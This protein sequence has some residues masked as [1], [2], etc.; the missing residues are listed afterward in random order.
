MRRTV[1]DFGS[2]GLPADVQGALAEA[3]WCH[4]GAMAERCIPVR[5]FHILVFERFVRESGAIRCLADVHGGTLLRY[6]EWLNT[7]C[8]RDGQPWTKSSRASAFTTLRKLLQWIERC[9]PGRVASIEYPFNPFPWRNRDARPHD[10]MPAGE[11]R[12]LLKACEA[13]I[14]RIRAGREAAAAQ[15]I[16]DAGQ[17]GTLGW[18][19]EHIDR[20]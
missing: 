7:Q 11:L 15:R 3:F 6:V 8:R 5:W 14:V 18:L 16:A 2:L 4:F 10:K 19:L 20:Q 13:D 17:P 12:A 9:R 1:I